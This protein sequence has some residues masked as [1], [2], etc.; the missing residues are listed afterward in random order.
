[1]CECMGVWVY[2]YECMGVCLC[3]LVNIWCV[4]VLVYTYNYMYVSMYVSGVNWYT[5]DWVIFVVK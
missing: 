4:N 1:M 2:G 3:V 5:V